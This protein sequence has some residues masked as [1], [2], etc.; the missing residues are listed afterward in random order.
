LAIKEEV[1]DLFKGGFFRQ[2][3]DAVPTVEELTN[4]TIYE[5]GLGRIK[6]NASKATDDLMGLGFHP[7]RGSSR[8]GMS[9]A[10]ESED[11]NPAYR[12]LSTRCGVPF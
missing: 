12:E 1:D 3:V 10:A 7:M 9:M 6:I 8:E 11:V 5:A 2:I 4:L